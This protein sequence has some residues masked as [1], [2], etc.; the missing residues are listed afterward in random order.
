M[1]GWARMI[2][3][4][5]PHEK[6]ELYPD[7]SPFTHA[8]AIQAPLRVF[9]GRHDTR[10]TP[11]QMDL[12]ARRMHELQKDFTLIWLDAGHGAGSTATAE[13]MQEMHM[14]FAY[15]VLGLSALDVD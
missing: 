11:R 4:G 10:A 6:A 12:F 7:R 14:K 5:A 1:Q 15:R 3:D 9:Q 13:R 2:F 8:A